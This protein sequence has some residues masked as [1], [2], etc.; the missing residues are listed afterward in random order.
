MQEFVSAGKKIKV[1]GHKA[2]GLHPETAARAICLSG[3]SLHAPSSR[4]KASS[5]SRRLPCLEPLLSGPARKAR[6]RTIDRG[7]RV[8]ICFFSAMVPVTAL[9]RD[10]GGR[11]FFRQ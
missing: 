3:V 9:P 4:P 6:V 8:T 7:G 2:F 10:G 11:P 5:Q 1:F